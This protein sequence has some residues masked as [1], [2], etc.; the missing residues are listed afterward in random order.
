MSTSQIARGCPK[1]GGWPP[2]P[3]WDPHRDVMVYRCGCGYSWTTEP[4]LKGQD[5]Q[6]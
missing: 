4:R 2:R 6:P 1:C 5:V 3:K